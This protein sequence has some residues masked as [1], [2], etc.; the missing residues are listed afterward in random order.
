MWSQLAQ[1]WSSESDAPI[2]SFVTVIRR[3][4]FSLENDTKFGLRGMPGLVGHR[5][6]SNMHWSSGSQGSHPFRWKKLVE[7]G[8]LG[9]LDWATD[10]RLVLHTPPA[11]HSQSPV[12]TSSQVCL[13]L[14]LVWTPPQLVPA[15]V[16]GVWY[17]CSV[18]AMCGICVQYVW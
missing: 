3:T 11:A 4:R 6:Q 8:K 10:L 12:S 7:E 9:W 13:C 1:S 5:N 18:C 17:V 16:C 2:C 15:C 14:N